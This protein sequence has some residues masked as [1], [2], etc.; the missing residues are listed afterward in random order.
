VETIESLA[1]V[2]QLGGNAMRKSVAILL[3]AGV[4]VSARNISRADDQTG[5][6][7]IVAKAIR[8][9]GGEEKLARY[10]AQTWRERATYFGMGAPEHSEAT[11][12]A[13]WP[14]KLKVEIAGEFTMVVNGDKG[15]VRTAGKT[16]DMSKEEL[17]EHIEGTYSVW[18]MSLLPLK[19]DAFKLM[20]LG[21]Q[22]VGDRP[23]DVVRVSR[24]GHS[25]VNLYFDK[26]TGLLVRI[27]TRYKEARTSNK[28][29]QETTFS[30]YKD[31]DGSGIKSPTKASIRR[32]GKQVVETDIEL[33]HIEKLDDLLF[34]KP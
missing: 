17:E 29:D 4:L 1:R 34:A 30:G 19:D 28:I 31:Q 25:D 12:A 32:N 8:M 13:Q 2:H 21:E 3:V 9:V 5:A 16:R 18:V 6:R 23:A 20:A 11:Y 33:K 15:W 24:Q 22:K 27:D 7:A 10:Q 14:D 26:E